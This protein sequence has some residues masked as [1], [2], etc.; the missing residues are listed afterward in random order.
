[1]S[2]I[3]GVLIGIVMAVLIIGFALVMASAAPEDEW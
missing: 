3:I 2:I 1:M